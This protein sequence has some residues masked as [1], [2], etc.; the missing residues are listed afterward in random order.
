MKSN[1]KTMSGAQT[2]KLKMGVLNIV[3]KF[4]SPLDMG[5]KI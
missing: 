2:R 5:S 3:A 1:N 4:Y